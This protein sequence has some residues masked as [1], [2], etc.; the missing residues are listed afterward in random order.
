[1]SLGWRV[2][3]PNGGAVEVCHGG[4]SVLADERTELPRERCG[5]DWKGAV[6]G[7]KRSE[8]GTPGKRDGDDRSRAALVRHKQK[9]KLKLKRKLRGC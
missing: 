5:N 7:A 2:P 4:G 3:I 1:M 6:G 9:L 8:H